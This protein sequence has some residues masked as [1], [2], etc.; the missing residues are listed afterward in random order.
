M[1][2]HLPRVLAIVL[3]IMG[4]GLAHAVPDDTGFA[5]AIIICMGALWVFWFR[6][7]PKTKE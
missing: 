6:P 7:V 5:G 1:M 4:I 3:G 2:H